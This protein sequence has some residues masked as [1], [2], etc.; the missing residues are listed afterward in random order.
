MQD[1]TLSV[2]DKKCWFYTVQYPRYFSDVKYSCSLGYGRT[3]LN[4]E[5]ELKFFWIFHVFC[6]KLKFNARK[7]S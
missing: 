3:D 4:L 6:G 2:D 5:R 1:A 7:T